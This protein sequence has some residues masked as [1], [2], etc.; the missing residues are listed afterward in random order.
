MLLSRVVLLPQETAYICFAQRVCT[1]ACLRGSGSK[2]WWP[3]WFW[4]L[5][6]ADD[7]VEILASYLWMEC[8]QCGKNR[9]TD[10]YDVNVLFV[11]IST[12]PNFCIWIRT[13][14]MWLPFSPFDRGFI[15]DT[16]A[17][18]GHNSTFFVD[19]AL[20]RTIA[21]LSYRPPWPIIFYY[22]EPIA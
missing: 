14:V 22:K 9:P 6:V 7:R 12:G 19:C 4:C 3:S 15:A 1:D 18:P 17:P 21:L 10:V 16:S 2:L 11:G 20:F 5:S 13:N 8:L